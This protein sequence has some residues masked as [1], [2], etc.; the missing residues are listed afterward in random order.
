MQARGAYDPRRGPSDLALRTEKTGPAVGL[1]PH[2]RA[3]ATAA[4]LTLPVVDLVQGLEVPD[5][6]EEVAVLLIGQRRT[7]VLD[8]LLQGLDHRPVET[9]HFLGRQRVGDAVVAQPGGEE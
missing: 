7:P 9:A 4:G 3:A 8:G 5:L 1:D 2:D 6:A